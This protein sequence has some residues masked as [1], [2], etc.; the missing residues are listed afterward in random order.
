MLIKGVYHR[1]ILISCLELDGLAILVFD[2]IG[3]MTHSV[4]LITSACSSYAMIRDSVPRV[5]IGGRD[6]CTHI[7]QLTD[8][9]IVSSLLGSTSHNTLG[10]NTGSIWSVAMMQNLVCT[11]DESG[12]VRVFD[13]DREQVIADFRGCKQ[14]RHRV[15]ALDINSNG[16]YVLSTSRDGSIRVWDIRQR[17]SP[18]HYKI[19]EVWHSTV[20]FHR[21]QSYFACGSRDGSVR[22]FDM[23]NGS[24]LLNQQE[25]KQPVN[26]VE[27]HPVKHQLISSSSESLV[28]WNM[29]GNLIKPEQILCSNVYVSLYSCNEVILLSSNL[30]SIVANYRIERCEAID[31][32]Y[33]STATYNAQKGEVVAVDLSGIDSMRY[34]VAPVCHTQQSVVSG[35][36]QSVD[37]TTA[38]AMCP[39]SSVQSKHSALRPITNQVGNANGHGPGRAT[40]IKSCGISL[41]EMQEVTAVGNGHTQHIEVLQGRMRY[42]CQFRDAFAVRPI[43]CT[44]QLIHDSMGKDT[45][46]R[47]A[48]LDI[49]KALSVSQ[50]AREK[51]SIELLPYILELMSVHVTQT[52]LVGALEICCRYTALLY[53]RFQSRLNNM[54]SKASVDKQLA[55]KCHRHIGLICNILVAHTNATDEVK[56]ESARL[57]TLILTA[58]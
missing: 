35:Q 9:Q 58:Q 23:R 16:N 24:L 38:F 4:A 28:V 47:V 55:N 8:N 13:S 50:R 46:V 57:L 52:S 19:R 27:F 37:R 48:V 26:T 43:E 44:K 33:T 18:Q 5:A 20:K 31:L 41:C 51:V 29:H 34:T 14:H 12:V 45:G 32:G 30:M 54:H 1:G 22:V 53:S 11:G 49:I 17:A 3:L 40:C 56:A 42:L 21:G 15:T 2:S 6:G 39:G 25:H 36:D 10:D 7:Y